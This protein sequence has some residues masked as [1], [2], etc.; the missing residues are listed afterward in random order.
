MAPR[1]T[2][3]DI[4]LYVFPPPDKARP[5]LILT[6]STVI[7]YLNTVTVAPITS[8]LRG[9]PS[10][11]VI[12]PGEGLKHESAINLDHVQTVPKARI[13]P[14]IGRLAPETLKQVCAALGVALGCDG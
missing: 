1:L 3:G 12:G 5:V 7:P 9:L 6:R 11:V 10:E 2:R 14:W 8:T 13:G 4:H